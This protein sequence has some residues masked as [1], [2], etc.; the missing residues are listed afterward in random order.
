MLSNQPKTADASNA[1]NYMMAITFVMKFFISMT[2]FV[3]NLQAMETYP[4]CLRQTGTSLGIVASNAFGVVGP[5]IVYLV[6]KR[7]RRYEYGLFLFIT[8]FANR[9]AG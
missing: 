8:T 1:D 3:V 7:C 2:F 6:S 9:H 5:Y 4:T